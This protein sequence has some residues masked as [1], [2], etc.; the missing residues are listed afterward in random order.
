[1]TTNNDQNYDFED[2]D[3]WDVIY[4]PGPED[5]QRD[6]FFIEIQDTEGQP[7]LRVDVIPAQAFRQ[8]MR[9][10]H[11]AWMTRKRDFR[12]WL[13]EVSQEAPNACGQ[14]DMGWLR[15]SWL[16]G[17]PPAH[18]AVFLSARKQRQ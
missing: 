2:G 5:F 6:E 7:K 4:T 16:N 1:M 18:A 15:Q 9:K 11:A 12:T 13:R 10:M 8:L 14:D 3:M 17:I